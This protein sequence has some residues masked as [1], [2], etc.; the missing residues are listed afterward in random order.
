MPSLAILAKLLTLPLPSEEESQSQR[1]T[2]FTFADYNAAVLRLVTLP[3][4]IL[5][6]HA[7]VST[8]STPS[9]N[10]DGRN[11][12]QQPYNSHEEELDITPELVEQFQSDLARRGISISFIS[13]SW[14]PTFVDLVFSG[15]LSGIRDAHA[16]RVTSTLILASETIYSPASLHAFSETLLDLLRRATSESVP[17]AGTKVRSKA[18]VAAK[19]VYFGVGGGMDE[20]LAVLKNIARDEVSVREVLDVTSGGVGRIVLEI[21][22]AT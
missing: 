15:L 6:W 20:F 17:E 5:T 22:M 11:D 21:E 19:K 7:V 4:I 2:H 9:T 3:N 13:G 12:A 1:R 8:T 18:Y 16:P 10:A 14:S